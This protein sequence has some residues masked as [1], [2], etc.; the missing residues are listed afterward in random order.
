MLGQ[1]WDTERMGRG[2]L[3]LVRKDAPGRGTGW[4]SG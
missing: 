3:E 4:R 1:I 2:S